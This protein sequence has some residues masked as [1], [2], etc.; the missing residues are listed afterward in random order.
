MK[1]GRLHGWDIS[2]KE[3]VALQRR[4]AGKVRLVPLRRRPATVAGADI[5]ID[6]R[7]GEGIAAVIVY[8]YPGLEEIERRSARGGLAY[9]YIPGLLSFREAPLLLKAF[10]RLER[11]PDVVL[12]DGQGI[13]HPRGLGLASHMGLWLGLPT[14]GC[15][16][17][18]LVG[19][20][21]EPDQRRGS[22]T[23]LEYVAGGRRRCVGACLRTRDRVKPIYVSPGH[24][25]DLESAIEIVMGCLDGT[26]IPKPTREADRLVGE[27]SRG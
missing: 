15:A 10:S 1:I 3:A 5:A 6:K 26:R 16:K 12:F 22:F 18:R 27:I 21:R 4:L 14:I 17:S 7:S 24:L 23:R 19:E 2:P 20:H 13:A 11:A 25:I 9:P 8:T